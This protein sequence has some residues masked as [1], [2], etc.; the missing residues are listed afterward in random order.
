MKLITFAV[1]RSQ[2]C[3]GQN[4]QPRQ[5]CRCVNKTAYLGSYTEALQPSGR[6]RDQNCWPWQL[7]GQFLVYMEVLLVSKYLSGLK[8]LRVTARVGS[9]EP[10]F[11]RWTEKPPCNCQGMQ[12]CWPVNKT[13]LVGSSDHS[14]I[15]SVKLQRLA[16]TRWLYKTSV[17]GCYSQVYFCLYW[18]ILLVSMT[19]NSELKL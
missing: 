14:K 1:S 13:A 9:F 8:T 16:V 12:F 6:K 15:V 2:F 7:H 5:F 3:C 11:S 18:E 4:F 19:H 17:Y 10:F